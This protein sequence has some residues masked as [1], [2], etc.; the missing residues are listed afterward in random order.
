MAGEGSGV[1]VYQLTEYPI[2]VS[3]FTVLL[4]AC[5]RSAL[6]I[7]IIAHISALFAPL[8]YI[9]ELSFTSNTMEIPPVLL[10][11]LWCGIFPCHAPV[12]APVSPP[13]IQIP[14]PSIPPQLSSF[15]C[16]G[17]LVELGHTPQW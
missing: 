12:F 1:F 3:G 6:M 4:I 7:L 14:W 15:G 13:R 16:P 10:G 5:I 9:Y 2:S 17:S 11:C 8:F